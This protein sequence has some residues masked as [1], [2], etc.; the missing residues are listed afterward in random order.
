MDTESDKKVQDRNIYVRTT[1][2]DKLGDKLRDAKLCWYG[3]VKRIEEG[4]MGK[5][6]IAI[7]V[8]G[9]RK[10]GRPKR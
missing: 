3:H 2:I 4:Y 6:V 8:P 5:R 1:K 10:R 9:R 7:M